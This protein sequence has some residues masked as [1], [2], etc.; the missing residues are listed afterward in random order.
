MIREVLRTTGAEETACRQEAVG[1][2]YG[3]DRESPLL[4]V[5]LNQI[6]ASQKRHIWSI[7]FVVSIFVV[8]IGVIAFYGVLLRS[9]A[10]LDEEVPVDSSGERK[11]CKTHTLK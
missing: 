9:G 5:F 8:L 11:L 3:D 2:E 6:G 10:V 1:T 4:A 7:S